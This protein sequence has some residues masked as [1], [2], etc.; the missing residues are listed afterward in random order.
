MVVHDVED[1][2]VTFFGQ[3]LVHLFECLE[4]LTVG[5]GDEWKGENIVSVIIICNEKQ[6]FSIQCS[7][8]Q[9]SRAVGVKSTVL[10]AGQCRITEDVCSRGLLASCLCAAMTCLGKLEASFCSSG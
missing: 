10:F 9:S 6:F 5:S 3:H 4:D 7:C 2:L 8:G 1:G